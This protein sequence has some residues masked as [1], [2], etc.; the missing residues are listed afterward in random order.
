MIKD[1]A[2]KI[3]ADAGFDF[4]SRQRALRLD[5]G[6][7][8]MNPMG[9]DRIKPWAFDGQEARENPDSA[10]GFSFSIV[11]ADPVFDPGADVP[12]GIVPY[13]EQSFLASISQLLAT[14]LQ[15]GDGGC[16]DRTALD[17]AQQHLISICPQQAIAG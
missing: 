4:L 6:A 1:R 3:V 17:E 9:F 13:Q 16:A 14:P 2:T 12:G 10:R 15:E 5:D 7:L 11:L 8:P